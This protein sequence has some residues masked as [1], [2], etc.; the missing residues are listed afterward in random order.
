MAKKPLPTDEAVQLHKLPA[1]N[2]KAAKSIVSDFGA[3]ISNKLTEHAEGLERQTGNAK[4]RGDEGAAR[5]YAGRARRARAAAGVVTDSPLT[6]SKA[7]KNRVALVESAAKPLSAKRDENGQPVFQWKQDRNT[8]ALD[9]S[10]KGKVVLDGTALPGESL[11]GIGFYHNAHE[12]TLAKSGKEDLDSA[13]NASAAASSRARVEDETSAYQEIM[14]AHQNNATV[15]MHPTLVHQLERSGVEVPPE[16][17]GTKHSVS[18]LPAHVLAGM[19]DPDI[20]HLAQHHSNGIDFEQLSKTNSRATLHKVISAVRGDYQ[21]DPMSSPKTWSYATNKR[22]ATPD[23]KDEYHWRAAHLAATI[24]GEVGKGQQMFDPWNLRDNNEGILSNEGHSTVDSWE[25]SSNFHHAVDERYPDRKAFGEVLPGNK[26]YVS[27]SDKVS[28]HPNP[29]FGGSGV[30]HA[31]GNAAHIEAAK[32]L[33]KK[34]QTGFTVPT[35]MVQEVDW[36]AN[37]RKDYA[38]PNKEFKGMVHDI[39]QHAA[40]HAADGRHTMRRDR[41]IADNAASLEK[42]TAMLAKG[43]KPASVKDK[44]TGGDMLF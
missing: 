30:Y 44:L 23:T 4:E 15:V 34:Y 7:A 28:V 5:G 2:A 42:S 20:R 26:T 43:K 3:N 33:E 35:A 31:F 13:I 6:V 40:E 10:G 19:A 29:G 24:R 18:E 8:K 1:K 38:D 39:N 25:H 17:F 11:A 21:Q 41:A 12:E 14:K 22:D 36:A 9:K 32:M 37:R 27:G 16:M